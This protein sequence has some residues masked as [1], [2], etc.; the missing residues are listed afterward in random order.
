MQRDF[1]THFWYLKNLQESDFLVF[2]NLKMMKRHSLLS[3]IFTLNCLPKTSVIRIIIIV[4]IIIIILSAK[5][6]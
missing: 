2:M 5:N 4:I 1:Y 6:Y 3:L